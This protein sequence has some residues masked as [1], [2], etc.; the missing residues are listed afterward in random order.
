MINMTKL[1]IIFLLFLTV[2][3]FGQKPSTVSVIDFVKVKNNKFPEALFFY[4]NNWKVYRD[5]A[6]KSN[7]ITSY[8][9]LKTSADS[10]A[11]FNLILITEYADSLQYKLAEDRFQKIIKEIRPA[12]PKLLNELK[13]TDF[14]QNV[15]SKQTETL[16]SSGKY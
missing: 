3:A 8:K 6:L 16:F 12:G 9:Y 13:P 10:I 15:F 11:D 14:K 7:Y 2:P 5:I 4:E 1:P